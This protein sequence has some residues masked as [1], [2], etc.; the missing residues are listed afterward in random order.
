MM[1][2]TSILLATL[3]FSSG[4]AHAA[5]VGCYNDDSQDIINQDAL[6]APTYP[7]PP[8]GA[9]DPADCAL[10][11]AVFIDQNSAY[12]PRVRLGA[13]VVYDNTNDR[14]LEARVTPN[15]IIAILT[16]RGSLYRYENHKLSTWFSGG[17]HG[18]AQFKLSREGV[19]AATTKDGELVYSHIGTG[20]VFASTARV[21]RL[22]ASRSGRIVAFL[23]SGEIID[24]SGQ[25]IFS[26]TIDHAMAVKIAANG[27]VVW[28]TEQ[29]RLGSSSNEML[30]KNA[31]DPVVS[32]KVN[33]TGRV[34]YATHE[35]KLGRDGSPLDIGARSVVRYQISNTGEVQALDSEG[36]T[37]L[38]R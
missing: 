15:G 19:L 30:Y 31:V 36:N 16:E 4:L 14:V 9:P 28:L 22:L 11:P 35:G 10:A 2:K 37:H 29:G 21:A 32:F 33:A 38:F 34:A 12:G 24:S 17:T 1:M 8:S 27:V 26:N 7:Y 18:V 20:N 13:E 6:P 23:T 3:L 5:Q 25:R